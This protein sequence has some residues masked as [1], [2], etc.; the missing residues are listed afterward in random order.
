MLN[1]VDTDVI[2][3]GAGAAGLAAAAELAAAGQSVCIVEAR[4]RVGGRIFTLNEPGLPVPLELGAEFIHGESP[5]ILGWLGR[6]G[7]G[8]VDVARS[9]WSAE[10]GGLEPAGDLFDTMKDGLANLSVPEHDLPF[11]EFLD[12]AG[13]ALDPR[14]REFARA[15]VEGFDAADA[16]R[17]STLQTLQEWE[18]S[19][20]ADAP[21]FRPVGGYASLLKALL[22]S[23]FA[24]QAQLRLNSVVHEVRWQRDAVTVAGIRLGQPFEL[25]ARK[26]V[27]TLPLGV[28]Q[29]P[30]DTSGAVN[31]S[32]ALRVKQKALEGLAM[33][34][35]FKVMLRFRRAF[36]ETLQQ[37]RYRNASFVHSP[38]TEF[39]TFWTTLP[40]RSPVMCAWTAGPNATRLAQLGQDGIVAR[41]LD[42]LM[43]VFGSIDLG[44]E[45]QAARVHDWQADPFAFGAYSYVTVGGAGAR[46]LLAAPVEDT[47]YFAGEATDVEGD[48]ATVGGALKSGKRAAQQI[49]RSP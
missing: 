48:A 40:L 31:F 29:R 35:V 14:A 27:I 24:D 3:I 9:R 43:T 30:A 2:V 46:E 18:G 41:A 13:P 21:T 11:S 47:L 38:Q 5:A 37:G 23:I 7:A 17:V 20:A 42:S 26:A 44:C 15:L 32:P 45:L 19:S 1:A 39:P 4:D 10:D 33:G 25:R 12:R 6:G 28:L 34:P 22:G 49:M 16:A 8:I 36:W